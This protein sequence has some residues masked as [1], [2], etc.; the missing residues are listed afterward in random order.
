MVFVPHSTMNR[1]WTTC[2]GSMPVPQP[3]VADSPAAATAPQIL[4][5]RPLQP[6]DPNRRRSSEAV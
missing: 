1:L 5:S 6:I 3:I 2:S 4:R